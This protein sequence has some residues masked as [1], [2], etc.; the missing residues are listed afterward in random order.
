M[1]ILSQIEGQY[2]LGECIGEETIIREYKE[3]YLTDT[4]DLKDIN[5]LSNGFLSHKVQDMIYKSL[6]DYTNKY[7]D[8]YLLSLANIS[9]IHLP[10]LLNYTHSK[11]CFGVSDSGIITGIPL[12]SSQMDN[13]K[14]DIVEKV[15]NHYSNIIGLHNKKGDSQINL[16]GEI[17]YDF[18]KLVQILKKHT[19]INIHRIHNKNKF[20]SGCKE[21]L[22]TINDIKLEEEDYFKKLKEYRRLMDIKVEYNNKYSVPFNKLIR[23]TEIMLEFSSYTSLSQDQLNELLELLQEKIIERGDVEDY[24]FCGEYIERS[25]FP[26]D[27]NMDRY[28]GEI[29]K[30]FLEEYKYFKIIQLRKNI[31]LPKF[32]L[33]NPIK[34]LNPLLN[35]VIVFSEQLKMDFYMIEIE[36]PFIKDI[37][38][39]IASKKTNRILERSYTENNP[40][41]V[42]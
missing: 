18:S 29:V 21:L 34:R 5:D 22:N 12:H 19:R 15:I 4:L 39:Y 28:Y 38:A 26:D 33:K 20:N 9:K 27:Y 30:I 23:A 37:N 13:L 17:Y 25:L 31:V 2:E 7:F 42:S 1:V 24:L 10:S 3:F 32:N 11:I 35:N 6:I 16:G 8:R 14:I 40:H 41:T 36:I